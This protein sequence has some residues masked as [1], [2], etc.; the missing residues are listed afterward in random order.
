VSEL[1]STLLDANAFVPSPLHDDLVACHVPFDELLGGGS[2]ER[3]LEERA[4]RGLSI[5]LVGGSGCGKS[6]VASYVFGRLGSDFAAIRVPVFYETEETIRRPGPFARF[7]LQKLLA[8]AEPRALISARERQ[9]MLLAASERL[10]TPTRTIG[11]SGGAGIDVWLLKGELAREVT[12]TIRGA[13]LSGS[14]DAVLQTIDRVLD[15][16]HEGGLTPVIFIDDTDRWL[17]VGDID[18]GPLV[19]GFFGTIV[20]M[21][22]EREC[23]LV[24]AVHETYLDMP[25]YR[26]G[27]RGFLTDTIRIP[28][29]EE[30]AS[31]AQIID[32]R[33]AIQVEGA[34]ASDVI[35]L[36]AL[37]RLF[38]YYEG[39]WGHSLRMTLQG[40][41]LA[42]SLAAAAGADTITPA[43]IDDAAAS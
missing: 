24:V 29:L 21:L 42:L 30:P 43:L 18:R 39:L 10:A 38:H 13:N 14:T 4:R 40:L 35:D 12:E 28:Q 6:G 1:L 31:L 20:R 27:T 25:A 16:I 9:E 2:V 15:A 8:D 32:R 33:V 3:A 34:S 26:V 5:A 36:H 23:G 11:R 19:A 17:Q 22:A 41:H 37:E 7:L